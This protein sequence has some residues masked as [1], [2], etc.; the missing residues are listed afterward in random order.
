MAVSFFKLFSP[1]S[2]RLCRCILTVMAVTVIMYTLLTLEG[3][4]ESN[5]NDD[6]EEKSGQDE[7][8][9]RK[10][11]LRPY[12]VKEIKSRIEQTHNLRRTGLEGEGSVN[13]LLHGLNVESKS[14]ERNIKADEDIP[15]CHVCGEGSESVTKH[16]T[17]PAN[18]SDSGAF[19]VVTSRYTIKIVQSNDT[20]SFPP[21]V[22]GNK[23]N[24]SIP[25]ATNGSKLQANTT[26]H[27]V[28]RIILPKELK[29]RKEQERRKAQV[30]HT[31][32]TSPNLQYQKLLYRDTLSH[33]FVLDKQKLLFCYVPK[34]GCS[35]WKRILM[36]LSG[37]KVS[38]K[39]ITSR[40]AHSRNKLTRLG[41][42]SKTQQ[43]ER[44]STYRKVMFV[45]EPLTRVLSAYKN[46]YQ[47]LDVYR[48]APESLQKVAKH[49][50]EKHRSNATHSELKTG[51][52]ITWTEFTNYL[53]DPIE[54]PKFDEHW[55][56]MYKLCSP[57]RIKYDFIGRLEN[58]QEEANY[59]LSHFNFTRKLSYPSSAN[60]HPTN[61][62]STNVTKYFDR[63]SREKLRA[64]WNIYRFD[65]ELFGYDKPAFIV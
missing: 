55:K 1:R 46:K 10:L 51:E 35:N 22:V 11:H 6:R 3:K 41:T 32:N 30:E 17:N 28:K 9:L 15:R 36:V 47:D 23:L 61:S 44:I 19:Q 39:D 4:D 50:M 57:C 62:A 59:V 24:T 58:I 27:T 42:L 48:L 33:V 2:G 16:Q 49:V 14:D 12:L 29:I 26:S 56:E 8:D 54:R 18:L 5:P 13:D 45:R 31:C 52:N 65:Y 53:V 43:L 21:K 38:M 7:N 37:R 40:E 63:F 34:V 25:T 60:S 64:L 20:D